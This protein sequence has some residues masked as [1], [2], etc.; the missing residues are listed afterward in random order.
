M[1]TIET[2]FEHLPSVRRD[3]TDQGDASAPVG[4][5]TPN[6]HRNSSAD[7]RFPFPTPG[8]WQGKKRIPANTEFRHPWVDVDAYDPTRIPPR[9]VRSP[10]GI[11]AVKEH[12]RTY[13]DDVGIISVDHP[14]RREGSGS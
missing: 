4:P 13:A 7:W 12:V 3:T 1:A 8:R 9:F 14:H 6:G 10:V 2:T 11:E 5:A